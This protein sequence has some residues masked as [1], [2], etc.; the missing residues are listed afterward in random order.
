MQGVA[1]RVPTG[2]LLSLPAN[3]HAQR[4]EGDHRAGGP[5]HLVLVCLILGK[6]VSADS[7]LPIPIN[8]TAA[9]RPSVGQA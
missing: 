7:A 6:R 8:S 9:A 4:S 1:S 2:R 5:S 3:T